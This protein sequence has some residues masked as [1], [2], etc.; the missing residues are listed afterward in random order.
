MDYLKSIE[1]IKKSIGSGLLPEMLYVSWRLHQEIA[2]R[3]QY[4]FPTIDSKIGKDVSEIDIEAWQKEHS[5]HA[6]PSGVIWKFA[7]DSEGHVLPFK[8]WEGITSLSKPY[9]IHHIAMSFRGPVLF[10]GRQL[11]IRDIHPEQTVLVDAPDSEKFKK[12]TEELATHH[13]LSIMDSI[14]AQKWIIPQSELTSDMKFRLDFTEEPSVF[15]L[16]IQETIG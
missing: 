16:L 11:A 13:S 10:H 9:A 15:Q 2:V 7:V 3:L 8:Q 6:S 14:D 1:A 12:I 4:I 5:M